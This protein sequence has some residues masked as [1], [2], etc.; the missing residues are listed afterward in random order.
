MAGIELSRFMYITIDTTAS[1]TAATSP[2][3]MSTLG[4]QVNGALSISAN[5]IDAANKTSAGWA[6][7]IAGLRQFQITADGQAAPDDLVL[8]KL[9]RNSIAGLAFNAGAV[10]FSTGHG[11]YAT[12]QSSQM[13]INGPSQQPTQWRTTLGLSTGVPALFKSP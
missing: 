13:E 2:R 12:C 8:D 6:P 4:N 10:L 5:T 9:I 7:V 1:G 3:I 11:Y